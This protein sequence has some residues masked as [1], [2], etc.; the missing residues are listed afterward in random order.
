MDDVSTKHLPNPDEYTAGFIWPCVVIVLIIV[1][2]WAEDGSQNATH[3]CH[4]SP[5]EILDTDN[6]I[7]V[8]DKVIVSITNNHKLVHWRRALIV[9]LLLTVLLLFIAAFFNPYGGFANG[10][11]VF[12]IS[13]FIFMGTYFGATFLQNRYWY[14]NDLIIIQSLSDLRDKLNQ[15][16]KNTLKETE[17][18][19]V[20][21]EEI[22]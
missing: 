20:V 11:L 17:L 18:K 21:S 8:I 1:L 2:I 7:E 15:Y 14:P 19:E 5:P 10:F 9:A 22:R 16:T 4:N 12:L 3:N 13:M 6:D